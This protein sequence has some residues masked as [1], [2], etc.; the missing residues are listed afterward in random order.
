[1][2][3]EDR[4]LYEENLEELREYFYPQGGFEDSLVQEIAQCDFRQRRAMRYEAADILTQMDKVMDGAED[5]QKSLDA[6]ISQPPSGDLFL[7]LIMFTEGLSFLVSGLRKVRRTV[8]SD[9]YTVKARELLVSNFLGHIA[10][11]CDAHVA[12]VSEHLAEHAK[13]S[14]DSLDTIQ[15]AVLDWIDSHLEDFDEWLEKLRSEE[16]ELGI[17][18]ARAGL[19][20]S[21]MAVTI[22]YETRARR[23]KSR[24]L[25][26]LERVQRHKRG[27]PSPPSIN[28]DVVS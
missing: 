10:E 23:Q 2:T 18:K 27:E 17:K 16:H 26:D 5:G 8:E 15:E 19:P 21:S 11:E 7:E 14:R 6:V 24:A 20:G 28:G 12:E 3:E 4:A 13:E 9:G 1:M 22:R 25:A